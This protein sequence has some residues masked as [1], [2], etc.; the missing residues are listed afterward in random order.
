MP[1]RVRRSAERGFVSRPAAAARRTHRNG[2][3]G[4]PVP[5]PVPH[6]A[7]AQT[8]PRCGPSAP[9]ASCPGTTCAFSDSEVEELYGAVF[10]MHLPKQTA[11]LIN[12]SAEGWP[13]GLVLMHEYLAASE[14]DCLERTPVLSEPEEDA[15]PDLRIPGPGSL[16]APARGTA[17]VPDAH[18]PVRHAVP[19][20]LAGQ[21][22]SASPQRVA[23]WSEELFRRNLFISLLDET[24]PVIRYH[25][26]FREFL[27]K[28]LLASERPAEIRK[29]LGRRRGILSP[30][31]ET[32]SAQ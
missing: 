13:A 29:A 26:L 21:L 2:P 11:V 17:A 10:G 12:R 9:T 27:Q 30:A 14:P 7:G 8:S 31:R 23:A 4:G 20:P 28:K 19:L 16:P 22:A 15:G 1:D 3:A 32:R 24:Q 6:P 5:D 25:S 18:V